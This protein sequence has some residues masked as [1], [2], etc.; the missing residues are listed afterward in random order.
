M[1][2]R[3]LILVEGQTEEKFVKD[4][5]NPAFSHCNLFFNVR[6]LTTKRV[7]NG[8]DFKGGVTTFGKFHNDA[9]RLLSNSKGALVT[10]LLDYY[11]LPTDFPGMSTRPNASAMQR[12]THVERAIA[13]SFGS[14]HNFLPF[15]AL[16][17][18]EAWVFSSPDELPRVMTWGGDTQSR[19]E[20]I[21]SEFSNPEEINE[22]PDHA[23][24]KRITAIFPSYRKTLHGSTTLKRIGLDRIRARCPHFNE[25]IGKIELF[26]K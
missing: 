25:W 3:V 26:A 17:E 15:L 18:F 1:I 12:V 21:C 24:S 4:V 6:I 13:E 22:R 8:P 5:L 23:P 16:H 7:K 14:P 19:F 20:K 10:T 11:G 9:V 2:R